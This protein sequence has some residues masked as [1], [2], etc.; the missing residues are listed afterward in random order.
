MKTDPTSSNGVPIE[1]LGPAGMRGEL[2]VLAIMENEQRKDQDRLQDN[3]TRNFKVEALLAKAPS[4][5]EKIKGDFGP[6]DGGSY[7]LLP[8]GQAMSRVRCTG[9]MFEFKKNS[10]N[11]QSL[12]AFECTANSTAEARRKFSEVVLPFVDYLSYVANCPIVLTTIRIDDPKNGRNAIEYVSPYRQAIFSAHISTLYPEMAPVHAM[13][14]EAKNS[15]SDFYTFLCYYKILEGLLGAVRNSV[16]VKAKAKG[17]TLA[18]R[19]EVVPSSEHI[20]HRFQA[21]IGK[22]IRG[23]FD[24]VLTPQFRNAVAHFITDDGNILN[25]SAFEH[26]SSYAEVLFVTELCV[27]EVIQSHALL[28]GGLYA[29]PGA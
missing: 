5:T 22:P 10:K 9:G 25:M 16:F 19:R 7:L 2:H 26:A 24:D 13:Y 27:R 20:A 21:H 15:H 28:L 17:I 6:E 12:V 23:F 29:Q 14:R 3:T 4:A 1:S 8:D 11:E 18:G